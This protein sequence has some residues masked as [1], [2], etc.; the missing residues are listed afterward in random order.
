[1]DMAKARKHMVDS[2]VRPNDVTDSILIKAMGDT[3]REL[4]V[5][6]N[7]KHL[8]YVEKDV[9]LFDGRWLLKARDFSKLLDAAKIRSDDLVLE[10]GAGFGY[11][12]A[13]MSAMGSVIV[14]LEESE[15][16]TA[17]ASSVCSELGIDNVA[18]VESPLAEGYTAQGPYDVI[19]VAGGIEVL[20]EKIFEQLSD[21]GGRLVAILIR[22]GV[23]HA[24][25]FTK[26]QGI[27]GERPLFECHPAGVLPGFNHSV[28]FV[29]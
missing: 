4:F 18:F 6:A 22:D 28:G 15:E 3:P 7:K 26:H 13:I 1:M 10:I 19:V 8:A 9:P 20:P 16:A 11:G 24:T 17:H 5:P 25:L 12:C 21:E 2:Q 29:F 27:V 14:G 23:G